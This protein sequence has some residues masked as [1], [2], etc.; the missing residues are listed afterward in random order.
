MITYDTYF[1]DEPIAVYYND[2]ILGHLPK[3]L[4]KTKTELCLV[5][6]YL[7]LE[8]LRSD[9][10]IPSAMNSYFNGTDIVLSLK[11]PSLKGLTI[12]VPYY[13]E[14]YCNDTSITLSDYLN[15]PVQQAKNANALYYSLNQLTPVL[16]PTNDFPKLTV[17]QCAYFQKGLYLVIDPITCLNVKVSQKPY[18]EPSA[19]GTNYRSSVLTPIT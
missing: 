6:D 1:I 11:E 4:I 2:M 17:K 9:Y 16:K 3:Q 5:F 13:L 7:E 8:N 19:L 12:T 18:K 10:K 15:V 14:G